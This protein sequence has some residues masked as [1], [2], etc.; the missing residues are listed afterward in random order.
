MDFFFFIANRVSPRKPQIVQG[1]VVLMIFQEV[2][3]HIAHCSLIK[4]VW[5]RN[6][7]QNR[8]MMNNLKGFEI[9][10]FFVN[11]ATFYFL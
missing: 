7:H 5:G 4:I 8:R 3:V 1:S 10:S 6:K 2:L 9:T 11:F